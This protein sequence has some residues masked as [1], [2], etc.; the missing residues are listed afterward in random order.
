MSEHLIEL[1][2]IVK[3]YGTGEAAF[4]ALGGIDLTI[5]QGEFVAIMGPSGSGKSTTMNII[6]AL[7][8]PTSGEYLFQGL[9]VERLTNDERALLR[10][11]F[12]GFVFQGFNLLARTTALENVELPLLYRGVPT[13]ERHELARAALDR[14]GLLQWE[15]H[16]PAEL[17]GGQQQRV[18]IARAI[19]TKPLLLMADE[20]T[21]SL[22]SRKSVEIM[23]L[24]TD[25]N[26]SDKITIVLVTHEMLGNAFLLAFRQIR[27]NPLR[28]LL[29]VLGIVIGVAAVITMV[30]V[31]NGATEAVKEQ[32]ESFGSNQL[33]LRKGQRMGPGGAA[34]APSF[35]LEDVEAL[36][37]QIAGVLS[38]A[39]QS[40]RSTIV[41]ANGKNWTTT[42]IGSSSDYFTTDNR[43]LAEGRFFEPAEEMSGAA[44]CVIGTTIQKELFGPGAPVI[45]E[46]LRVNSFSCRIV[47]LLNEKGTA[48]MGGDQDDL[49]VIPFNTA[50]RRLI[51]N[52]RVNTIL[53]S[54]DP[55][56]DRVHLKGLV[57][58]LMRER[59]SLSEGD[60]DNFSILDTAEVAEKVASTTQIMTAL[61]GA[62]AAVSL[63]VGGIGIMNIMLV[64]VTERTR[65]IGVRLAIGA[66]AR[67]VLMQFLI[68][69]VV[70]G[71]M[72][73]VIGILLA[74][75]S[76][77]LITGWMDVPYTF[78]PMINI[79]SFAFAALTGVIFGYFP[80][81][82]AARLDPIEAVRHE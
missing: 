74:T 18:A 39:P 52:N 80:A 5:D 12:M 77:Y 36:E 16:T 32:I 47:G 2:R 78:D 46:M 54:I 15:D 58:D 45:G 75:G 23:E 20:P 21:G 57:R 53:I 49:V 17:S 64:S 41:V 42:I 29:T 8:S 26:K 1:R 65:E 70:L 40:Q 56:S 10:R 62:V 11:R 67:E 27:R 3:R 59:R 28:S 13:A 66:T 55:Q 48:A 31:G 76:S 82:R 63:L 69:A 68:E 19:V 35:K 33:M 22:D 6:G 79:V 81:R 72:G 25:L 38:A 60:D 30:T 61:L 51:G 50:A 44:V 43:T 14:V 9:H 71:C 73:G 7:D 34:G 37:D 24:L 4:N